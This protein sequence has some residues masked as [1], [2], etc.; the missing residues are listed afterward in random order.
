MKI[1]IISD[2]HDNLANIEKTLSILK[3]ESIQILLHCGDISA[4]DT[5]KTIMQGF[6]GKVHIVLGNADED[7]LELT[8]LKN[9]YPGRLKI[10][11]NS[12]EIKTGGKKIAFNHFPE[13]A[14]DL[15]SIKD[16]DLIFY[17]HTHKPWE[18]RIGKTRLVNPGNLA[19]IFYGPTF[20]IYDTK[21]EKLELK[22]LD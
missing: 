10:W 8:N 19:G 5:L 16:Y 12:G 17:G 7:T 22:I 2:T 21:N 15:A 13:I 18:E 20:A 1:A 3:K 11:G 4:L 9:K 6:L 14:K